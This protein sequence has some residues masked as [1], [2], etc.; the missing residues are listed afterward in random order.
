MGQ[1]NEAEPNPIMGFI[2][3]DTWKH[4][5]GVADYLKAR[6]ISEAALQYLLKELK[7]LSL[8]AVVRENKT[9]VEVSKSLGFHPSPSGNGQIHWTKRKNRTAKQFNIAFPTAA[10]SPC[11][12]PQLCELG[13]RPWHRDIRDQLFREFDVETGRYGSPRVHR[14][15]RR[16]G[17]RVKP[18]ETACTYAPSAC[19]SCTRSRELQWPLAREPDNDRIGVS[20]QV[21]RQASSISR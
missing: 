8:A 19:T 7:A 9:E 14:E 20:R 12:R 3:S 16:R 10:V 2:P 15:L 17:R 5:L 13:L 6:H 18:I 21:A 11:V 1:T 4:F